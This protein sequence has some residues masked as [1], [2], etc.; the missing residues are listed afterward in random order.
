MAD[1][2]Q[3]MSTQSVSWEVEETDDPISGRITQVDESTIKL[4]GG[5]TIEYGAVSLRGYYPDDPE[6]ANQDS[7]VC[8]ADFN[9][10]AKNGANGGGGEPLLKRSF[11]GVFDGPSRFTASLS[12]SNSVSLAL[13]AQELS[14]AAADGMR[15]PFEREELTAV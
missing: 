12:R 4:P 1:R 11:F 9:A 3:R 2:Q 13:R 14:V 10:A 8:I 15:E 5:T 7:H 6:K